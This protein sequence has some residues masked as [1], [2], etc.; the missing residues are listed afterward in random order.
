M[1][2]AD[3][4]ASQALTCCLPPP[5]AGIVGGPIGTYVVLSLNL[6]T[7]YYRPRGSTGLA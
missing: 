4:S 1:E 2:I 3:E 5:L 7:A 6:G